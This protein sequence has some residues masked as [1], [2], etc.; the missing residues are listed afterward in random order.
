M[1]N[2]M[3]TVEKVNIQNQMDFATAMVVAERM[4][5]EDAVVMIGTLVDMD[6]H[7]A[8]TELEKLVFIWLES[9]EQY[10]K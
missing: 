5:A 9:M 3:L 6:K 10:F 4:T 1:I 8:E 2:G 7:E